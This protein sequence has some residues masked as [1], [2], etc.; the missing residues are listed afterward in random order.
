MMLSVE[1]ESNFKENIEKYHFLKI[2]ELFLSK[3]II[4]VFRGCLCLLC[5]LSIV[6]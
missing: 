3:F 2:F 6:I 4:I 1:N 5:S